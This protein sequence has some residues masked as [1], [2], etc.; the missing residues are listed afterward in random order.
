MDDV[1]NI[2]ENTVLLNREYYEEFVKKNTKL[3]KNNKSRGNRIKNLKK[4]VNDCQIA[5]KEN[6][7]KIKE[8]KQEIKEIT[9]IKDKYMEVV[10]DKFCDN[11]V[12]HNELDMAI[13]QGYVASEAFKNYMN[14]MMEKPDLLNEDYEEL[15]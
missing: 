3:V 12:L 15:Q 7:A 13:E 14:Q 6:K 9:S 1:I 8:L 2:T 5:N 4:V 11:Q 10:W